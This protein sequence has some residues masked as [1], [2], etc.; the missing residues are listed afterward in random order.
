MIG[1]QVTRGALLL[2][3]TAAQG[4][5]LGN[6]CLSQL[7]PDYEIAY[8]AAKSVRLMTSENPASEP[9]APSKA[10]HY[11]IGPQA[12]GLLAPRLS[13]SPGLMAFP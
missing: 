2:R 8:S 3:E 5:F 4:S 1:L 7:P 10:S 13:T 11:V 9:L 12:L 6:W